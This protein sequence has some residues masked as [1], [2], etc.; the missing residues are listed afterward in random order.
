[1]RAYHATVVVL[2]MT[3]ALA[4][5]AC[6]RA[7]PSSPRETAASAAP[8]VPT[9]LQA[10]VTLR[11]VDGG[12]QVQRGTVSMTS[13]GDYRWDVTLTKDTMMVFPAGS[14][15]LVLYNAAAHRLDQL[16]TDAEGR[17]LQGW[18]ARDSWSPLFGSNGSGGDLGLSRYAAVVS[19]ALHDGSPK[20]HIVEV[21]YEGRP[22]WRLDQPG[23]YPNA[24]RRPA[25][26]VRAIVDE[27]SGLLLFASSRSVARGTAGTLE[28]VRLDDLRLGAN[29]PASTFSPPATAHGQGA[30]RSSDGLAHFSGLAGAAARVGYAALL[31][32]PLP[33]GYVLTAVATTAKSDPYWWIPGATMGGPARDWPNMPDTET[34][35][36]FT[37]GLSSFSI[38]IAP[39]GTATGVA[40]GVAQAVTRLPGHATSV[41]ASGALAGRTASYWLDAA[42][43]TSGLVVSG[44]DL[45]VFI[46]GDLSPQEMLRVAASLKAYEGH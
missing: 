35:L 34:D 5:I 27:A 9:S 29:L 3:L 7:S 32:D 1:M 42:G 39:I 10:D 4:A 17:L 40:T 25:F 44:H 22:A 18:S 21:T 14:R 45:L 26:H 20:L 46:S 31:P 41:L 37:R 16:Y 19:A 13:Q 28:E 24:P 8:G 12:E 2:A 11:W 43:G 6:G 36:V 30:M 33:A 15:F 23:Y 38:A